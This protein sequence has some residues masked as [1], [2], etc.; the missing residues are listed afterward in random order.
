MVDGGDQA[1]LYSASLSY[2]GIAGVMKGSDRRTVSGNI[3]LSYQLPKALVNKLYLSDITV[4]AFCNNVF[5]WTHKS[6]RYI[7]PE[8]S[9]YGN[10]LSGLFGE[11][12]ANPSCRT[13][14]F[15]IGATLGGKTK[16]AAAPVVTTVVDNSALNELNEQIAALRAENEALKNR[17]PEKEIVTVDNSRVVTFP[18]LVNFTVNTTDVVNREKVNL[19][20]VAQMI[21][22]TPE[23]K[24]SVTGYADKQTGTAEGNAKLASGR[25]QNVY[26]ILVNQYGVPASQLVKDSKGG[27]D[28]M[29]MNDEQ[30]SRSVIISEMK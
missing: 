21:K 24:Y 8:T 5:T 12:Y 3:T 23:K 16:S 10:D 9:S 26:D 2:N 17:K 25:A 29:Y 14:G 20:T 19:E 1:M 18:Y 7:D 28:Y 13:F 6:N 4:S 30:L 15:N 27:V 22:A 11:L